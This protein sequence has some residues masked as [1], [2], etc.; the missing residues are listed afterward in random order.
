MHNGRIQFAGDG[1]ELGM[2][3]GAAGAGQDRD[4][5]RIV[6]NFGQLDDFIIGRTN[7]RL[8]RWKF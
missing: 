5:L 6:E 2:R 7:N 1:N 4:V 3:V 8:W